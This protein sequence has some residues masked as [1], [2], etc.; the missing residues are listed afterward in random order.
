MKIDLY[1]KAKFISINNLQEVTDP[2]LLLRGAIPSPNGL[3]STDIFGVSVKERKE[4]FAY[5]D[6]QTY[7]LDPFIYKLLKRMNRKIVDIVHGTKYFKI[8]NGELIEDENG[9]TGLSFLYKNWEKINFEKNN[10]LMRGE[11]I[12]VL[13]FY[14]KNVIFTKYWIVIPAFYRD[15]NLQNL[16]KGK[17]SH[18]TINDL[19]A[20]LIRLCSVI[21]QQNNFDFVLVNTEAKIQ[22]TLVEIYDYLKSKIEKKQ[23][24]IRQS[25]LGK[26]VDYGSRM[27]ISAPT[28]SANSPKDMKI[29]FY[30]TGIPLAQC[31]SLF[32]PFMV[33]HVK[34]FFRQEFERTGNKYPVKNKNGDLSYVKLKDPELFFNDEYIKKQIDRFIFAYEDRFVPIELP[35]ENSDK[36]INMSFICR[37]YKKGEPESEST[38]IERPATWCDILYQAAIEVTSDKMVYVTRYPVNDYFG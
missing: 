25:I 1:D 37:I 30:H 35:V 5:I 27:V 26:S 34:N 19:Y 8:E 32:Y 23:G 24:M 20:K 22:D 12:D 31:C 21:K 29:D 7:F 18:H 33:S 4:R 36:P 14:K 15:L 11:R 10:S 16:D 13:N 6:L 9:E 28:F 17:I 2:V 3:L 38:I